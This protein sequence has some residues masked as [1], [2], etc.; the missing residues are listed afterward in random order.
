MG[1]PTLG[2]GPVGARD[3]DEGDAEQ[4]EYRSP[5]GGEYGL[6]GILGLCSCGVADRCRELTV[7]FVDH[8]VPVHVRATGI[9]IWVTRGRPYLV[10][11][12]QGRTAVDGTVLVAGH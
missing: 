4:C 1:S 7:G 6:A 3:E 5:R 9:I 2:L 8:A 12:D 10:D 11:L